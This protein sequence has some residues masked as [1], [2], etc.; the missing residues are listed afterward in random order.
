MLQSP[1]ADGPPSLDAIDA[2]RRATG[3]MQGPPVTFRT[4]RV[5]F[6]DEDTTEAVC[7]GARKCVSEVILDLNTESISR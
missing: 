7:E 4:A 2:A 5:S 3:A 6:N 1:T